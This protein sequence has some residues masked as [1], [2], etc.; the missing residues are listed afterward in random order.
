MGYALFRRWR[1]ALRTPGR[2]A[3]RRI[4]VQSCL[5]CQVLRHTDASAR[6]AIGKGLERNNLVISG[7]SSSENLANDQVNKVQP[8]TCWL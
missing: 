6:G 2:E 1:H 7:G 3:D 8:L 4:V 5:L